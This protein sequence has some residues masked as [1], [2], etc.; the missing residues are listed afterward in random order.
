MN[1]ANI[2]FKSAY[3]TAWGIGM[4][5]FLAREAWDFAKENPGELLLAC[6]TAAAFDVAENVEDIERLLEQGA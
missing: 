3:Y 1:T 4:T 6:I 5:K 2:A